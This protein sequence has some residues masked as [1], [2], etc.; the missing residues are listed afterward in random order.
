MITPRLYS[1]FAYAL[2]GAYVIVSLQACKEDAIYTP[3]PNGSD[4]ITINA[5]V[6]SE[7]M[8]GLSTG[9]SAKATHGPKVKNGF[10]AVGDSPSDSIFI[11]ETE[12]QWDVQV[13][14][15]QPTQASRGKLVTTD[16]DFSRMG[17]YSFFG[18]RPT[19]TWYMSNVLYQYQKEENY[20]TSADPHYLWPGHNSDENLLTFFAYSPFSPQD[21]TDQPV[22]SII[23]DNA[24]LKLNYT[25]PQ[26]VADQPDLLVSP[27]TPLDEDK[28]KKARAN[29]LS[30][31]MGHALTAIR[32]KYAP[33]SMYPGFVSKI[34]IKN[35]AG[36]GIYDALTQTWDTSTASLTEFSYEG[37]VDEGEVAG[38][39]LDSF[40]HQ[41]GNLFGFIGDVM[42]L[43]PQTSKGRQ[44]AAPILEVTF[45]DQATKT[46]HVF[47]KEIE[48]DWKPG[49]AYTYTIS[50]TSMFTNYVFEVEALGGR[51]LDPVTGNVI[52][53]NQDT[54]GKRK[55]YP[56][57]N[58]HN[59]ET[60]PESVPRVKV[61]SYYEVWHIDENGEFKEEYKGSTPATWS[62]VM[63]YRVS[64]DPPSTG[65]V[66]RPETDEDSVKNFQSLWMMRHHH[67]KDPD[68]KKEYD[69]PIRFSE[70]H[71]NHLMKG[72]SPERIKLK[73]NS[74]R[75][76]ETGD[77]WADAIDLSKGDN[78]K[79]TT[80]NCYI[81]TK[82]GWYKLPLVY[83][84]AIKNDAVNQAAYQ[85]QGA[86]GSNVLSPFLRHDDLPITSP[87]IVENF[88]EENF[89][90]ELVRFQSI[91]GH[92]G[93]T[94]TSGE[95]KLTSHPFAISSDK[96]YLRFHI[97]DTPGSANDN[98]GGMLPCNFVLGLKNNAGQIV[99]TWHIWVTG[100]FL[101]ESN[102]YTEL[103]GHKLLSHSLGELGPCRSEYP[104][105]KVL[106]L[107][108][109]QKENETESA[110]YAVEFEQE[111]FVTHDGPQTM[112]YQYGRM[113]PL[114]TCFW[115][116]F[117]DPRGQGEV[118]LYHHAFHKASYRGPD[119]PVESKNS[120][121]YV[122][123]N[124]LT[125][126]QSNMLVHTQQ[127]KNLWNNGTS[128]NPIKTV[129][130]PSPPG[131]MVPPSTDFWAF[132]TTN[133]GSIS[134]VEDLTKPDYFTFDVAGTFNIP[135]GVAFNK[136]DE[137]NSP[138][139]QNNYTMFWTSS[140]NIPKDPTENYTINC[141]S[142]NIHSGSPT[143][144]THKSLK[145]ASMLCIYPIKEP[146]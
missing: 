142:V 34:T 100:L 58:M 31:E 95:S 23:K 75:P 109:Q 97:D 124:P 108:T 50:S 103:S 122:I 43:M 40:T 59:E 89:T 110:S 6:S 102:M 12:S 80:A 68:A 146:E 8:P 76:P 82:P 126:F 41:G 88:P 53:E 22:T 28:I 56:C 70:S 27:L 46:E 33:N 37:H 91:A 21:G 18:G 137:D 135:R 52:T 115:Q 143:A 83:G 101:G 131:F 144:E 13:T 54:E 64:T 17:V 30:L 47:R 111:G 7:W 49:Y 84:N 86:A 67:S 61:K 119:I 96:K 71:E 10:K 20:W 78:G 66:I 85:Y 138:R 25:V 139:H 51:V 87:W 127:Y 123:R 16:N 48:I 125:I 106:L 140:F 29:G 11:F 15:P 45:T 60:D 5:T 99:W 114:Y 93:D 24:N 117:V 121:G 136:F 105:S 92:R 118:E 39:H 132:M 94:E 63:A 35:I 3:M 113:A 116:N 65:N 2:I 112:Y 55:V 120:I 19:D 90:T 133:K 134:L 145:P 72:S 107:L 130:D 79:M 104:K 9:S 74:Y 4:R 77:P 98:D 57:G 38:D 26:K 73:E 14:E 129:Y 36:Q 141:V 62:T 128:T 42:I 1:K 44:G 69:I 81:V 32:F